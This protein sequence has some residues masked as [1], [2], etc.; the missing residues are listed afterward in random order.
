MHTQAQQLHPESQQLHPSG[1]H[2][3]HPPDP[4]FLRPF[5]TSSSG[6]DA[7]HKC[8]AVSR[9]QTGSPQHAASEHPPQC[10]AIGLYAVIDI[11]PTLTAG[12]TVA[13]PWWWCC[14]AI[15]AVPATLPESAVADCA[16][17]ADAGWQ[18]GRVVYVGDLDWFSHPTATRD[19]APLNVSD[20]FVSFVL[21]SPAAG[22]ISEESAPS[23]ASVR[24]DSVSHCPS[25]AA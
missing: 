23:T 6:A 2:V 10:T 3:Q 19:G 21:R 24:V 7:S 9:T 1:Q 18:C 25:I 13:A 12:R 22:A 4:F 15:G 8:V 14:F 16:D 20:D 5:L 17:P 11:I